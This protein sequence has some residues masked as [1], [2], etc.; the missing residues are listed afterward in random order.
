MKTRNPNTHYRRESDRD[1]YRRK[2]SV[3]SKSISTSPS[4]ITVVSRRNRRES[5]HH[6]HTTVVSFSHSWSVL[7][8]DKLCILFL[9]FYFSY[10]FICLFMHLLLFVIFFI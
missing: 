10:L 9:S 6:R 5:D 1:F 8:F 4:R 2:N 7:S 3:N